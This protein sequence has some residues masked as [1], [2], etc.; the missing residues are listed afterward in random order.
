MYRRQDPSLY[1]SSGILGKLFP[2]ARFIHIVR[3]GRDVITS[4]CHHAYRAGQR[5]V[6]DK[7]RPEYFSYT[8]QCASVWAN[9]VQSAEKF[10]EE[11]P[12]RYLLVKYENMHSDPEKTL[13]SILQ[14]LGVSAEEKIV[15][16]C[17]SKNEFKLFSGGREKG[18]EDND[19]YFRTGTTE[20]WKDFLTN[21]ALKGVY[22]NAG[23]LL[24][25]LGYLSDQENEEVKLDDKQEQG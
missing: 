22:T 7:T 18:E 23:M 1:I 14:Y 19:S 24:K 3:D 12:E 2:Q 15:E 16:E 21:S 4:T 6:I 5:G 9:N 8:A 20:G 11:H 17:I 13:I 10:G 25:K